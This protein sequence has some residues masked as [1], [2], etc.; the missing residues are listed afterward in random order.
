MRIK[1]TGAEN[2]MVNGTSGKRVCS[3]IQSS[4]ESNAS[5]KNGRDQHVN[6][7]YDVCHPTVENENQTSPGSGQNPTVSNL[8]SRSVLHDITNIQSTDHEQLQQQY[9]DPI[10]DTTLLDTFQSSYLDK[11]NATYVCQFCGA[12][13]WLSERLKRLK[14]SKRPQFSICCCHGKVALRLMQD[15]PAELHDLFFNKQ[16]PLS[17]KFFTQIR[18]Y[19]N[20]FCFTSMGGRIDHSINSKG[21][22]PYSFVLS[23]QNHHF[24]GSL[25]PPEGNPPVYA[26]LYIYDTDNE[27]SN[28]ISTVS[29]NGGGENFDPG[30]VKLIKGC[31]DKYNSIVK[32]YRSASEIIKHDEVHDVNIRL[33]RNSSSS[34][35]GPQ[36]NM[37]TASELAALIVGDFDNSYT[38][39][40]I[41]VKRQ[42]GSLQRIDEL[43][44]SY[45]PLQYPL[46]FH[47]G[48]NGYD[49]SIEHGK[50]SLLKTKKKTRLTPREY[51]AFR[52]MKR[53]CERSVI[54]HGKK[55]LQRFIVDGYSM[56]ESDRLNYIRKHQKELRVDL[57]SG[58]S[59]AV[60]RGETDPSS[61]GRRVILPSSFTGGAR[62]M[63]QNY[64]DAMAICAW[65]GYP[66]IFFN[67]HMQPYVA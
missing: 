32:Q 8:A 33:I 48:D 50:E 45:L 9:T 35:I 66:D 43:H 55:L 25:L 53:N 34:G 17:K 31:L 60:T 56:V 12:N 15:P 37:P 6:E 54:L 28:R 44:M 29:R 41:I 59:D 40:D 47:Y 23:G 27:I 13:M 61:M 67:I 10:I 20:M 1:R 57:Y 63:I 26:Q 62:Y 16:Q 38:N 52:L 3:D 5:E 39:R 2:L 19:N 14:K 30:I 22:G 51:L 58:L 21:G 24:I 64:Q 65:A 11:G 46:F 18:L 49:P 42:S 36:Y 4:N 7:E